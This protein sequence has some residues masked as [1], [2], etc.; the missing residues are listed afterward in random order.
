MPA[1]LA[2]QLLALIAEQCAAQ[3]TVLV[4]DDLQ[5]ADHATITL[6]GQLARAAGQ[7]PLLL[8]GMMRPVPQRE[9]L[10]GTAGTRRAPHGCTPPDGRRGGLAE[11]YKTLAGGKPDENLMRTR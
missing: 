10:L 3:P 9:D 8:I 6:W 4:I 11:L 1:A 5:W 2:E 7:I